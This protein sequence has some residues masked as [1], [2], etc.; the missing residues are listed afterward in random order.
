MLGS[1]AQNVIALSDSIF[2]YHLSEDDFAA[3][4][5]VSVFYL[6]INAIGFGFSKGGQIMIARRY[7]EQN[8]SDVGKT[9]RALVAFEIILAGLMFM[10]LWYG[11]PI[12][13][14]F[15]VQSD[16]I[17]DKS[18][19]YLYHRSWGVFFAYAGLCVIALYMGIARSRFIIYDTLVLAS[20]NIF[21]DYVLIYG[22]WG[23]PFM[24]IKGAG[25]ASSTAEV[26]AIVIFFI[27]IL[28]DRQIKPMKLFSWGGFNLQLIKDE[29]RIS[30]PIV[31]Q[32]AVSVGSWFVFFSLV[33]KMGERSLAITNLGRVVYLILSIPCWGFASGVN[34][35]VSNNIGE[36]KTFNVMPIIYK[37]AKL[38]LA[39]TLVLG[40]PI[41]FLPQYLLYPI[42]GSEDMSLLMASQPVLYIILIILSIFSFSSIYFN[43]LSGTGA[44]LFA[45][46]MQVFTS[47]VYLS[48]L[49]I[50]MM[51]LD[52]SL[53]VAWSI[54]IFYWLLI[55]SLSFYYL[56]TGKWKAMKV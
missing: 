15:L 43:G 32:Y 16:I 56:R 12:L 20:V 28:L 5:F 13:F 18:L 55:F 1:A 3:I 42:L 4:G 46:K 36:E 24:G 31:I 33:E 30:T 7:G 53:E 41:I 50:V 44:T 29:L 40:I 8:L 52:S 25:L 19:E 17:Y 34:T 38:S 39:S 22:K 37:T 48:T 35:M 27:Y 21:L 49:Y 2:L 6:M 23:F 47:F 51:V 9:F 10:F 45:L 14:D 11:T 26:V 54:E